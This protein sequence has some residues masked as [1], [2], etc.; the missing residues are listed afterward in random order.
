[1]IYEVGRLECF[2]KEDGAIYPSEE[3]LARV[4]KL[5]EEMEV[6]NQWKDTPGLSFHYGTSQ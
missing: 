5:E 3:N 4:I 6:I 1:M 2:G